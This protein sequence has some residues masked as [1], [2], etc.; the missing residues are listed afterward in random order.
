MNTFCVLK[1]VTK[2]FFDNEENKTTKK[3]IKYT[4]V[5]VGVNDAILLGVGEVRICVKIQI[6]II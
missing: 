3:R 1:Y 4:H 2:V 5:G 6:R